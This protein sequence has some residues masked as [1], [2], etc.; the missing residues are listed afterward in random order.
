MGRLLGF[1]FFP[2]FDHVVTG[3]LLEGPG[4]VVRI[5]A[6][7][8]LRDFGDAEVGD[9]VESMRAC[10]ISSRTEWPSIFFEPL[11]E[12]SA[13][14]G[15]GA[16]HIFSLDQSVGVGVDEAGGGGGQSLWRSAFIKRIVGKRFGFI[17]RQQYFR[18]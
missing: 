17:G 10:R 9:A 16:Y 5:F 14:Q 1:K 7:V 13:A 6:A 2:V 11:F 3:D 4:Q 15:G 8:N 18:L 12:R